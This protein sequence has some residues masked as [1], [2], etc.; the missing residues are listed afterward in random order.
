[1]A[2]PL[3]AASVVLLLHALSEQ[4]RQSPKASI[5]GVIARIGS[6]EPIP[7]VEVTLRRV[8][9][10]PFDAAPAADT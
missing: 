9:A 6:G 1:M 2:M 10:V 8:V 5:E 4:Q 7:G 3:L